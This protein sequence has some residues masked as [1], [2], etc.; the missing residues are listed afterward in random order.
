MTS[1]Q[2]VQWL[3][4]HVYH[5]KHNMLRRMVNYPDVDPG[6]LAKQAAKLA[7]TNRVRDML[8]WQLHTQCGDQFDKSVSMLFN[9]TALL[10]QHKLV[11]LA[12][13]EK[14]LLGTDER[15]LAKL[16]SVVQDVV[17][18]LV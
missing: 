14:Y 3:E 9:A 5:S 11:Q 10:A 7:H 16:N 15:C 6:Q 18:E 1:R 2:C 4:Q 13:F 17:L 12:G 8:V